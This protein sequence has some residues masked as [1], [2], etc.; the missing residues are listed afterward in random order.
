[1]H[2]DSH[3]GNI[4]SHSTDNYKFIDPDGICAEPAYDLGVIMR[5]YSEELISNPIKNGLERCEL[6]SDISKINRVDIWE[7]GII[8]AMA[9]GL[10]C[11]KT[12]QYVTGGNLIAL[13]KEWVKYSY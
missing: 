8:Q 6:L 10:L 13:A 4:L 5:E 3:E 12:K 9:S 1:M 2:G 11:M 7:W